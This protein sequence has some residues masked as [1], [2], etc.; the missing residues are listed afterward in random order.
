MRGLTLKQGANVGFCLSHAMCRATVIA[1]FL[2][3]GVKS[4][5]K[6]RRE[7]RAMHV[8][9]LFF[10]Q[11]KHFVYILNKV[12]RMITFTYAKHSI[13]RKHGFQMFVHDEN[14]G[15]RLV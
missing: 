12:F 4:Y 8:Y 13:R 11:R 10:T 1:L 15:F 7:T 3:P 2:L 6:S 9:L 5:S 14:N